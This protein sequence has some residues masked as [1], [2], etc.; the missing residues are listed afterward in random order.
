MS[1]LA[2]PYLPGHARTPEVPL[3]HFLP[4]LP[5][6]IGAVWLEQN[7]RPGDWVLDP[8]GASP[9][10]ALEAARAGRRVLVA[11]N[12]PVLAFMLEMLAAAPPLEAYQSVLVEVATSR[13]GAE[14][15]ERQILG[16]YQSRCA[17]CGVA[18]QPA[19][20]IWRKD[21]DQPFARQYCCP[22][23]GDEGERPVDPDDLTTL[24]QL[25]SAPLARARAVDR[26]VLEDGNLQRSVEE[27]LQIYRP[28]PLYVLF[29]LLNKMDALNLPPDRLRCLQAL[30]LSLCDQAT[31]LWPQAGGRYRPRQLNT[32]AVSLE[33]NLWLAL[34]QAVQQWSKAGTPTPLVRYPD[35]PPES[36]GI[37]LY[38]GR[39]RSLLP[40]PSEFPVRAVLAPL[41]RTN[42]AFWTLSALWSGWLFGR[43]AVA[44][45]KG[46]LERQR[47]D[48]IWNLQAMH[49]VLSALPPTVP[50]FGIATECSPGSLHSLLAAGQAAG[51][52]LAGLALSENDRSAQILW[53]GTAGSLP[54]Y[55]G[56]TAGLCVQAIESALA[57]RNEPAGQLT[58][59]SACLASLAASEALPRDLTQYTAETPVRL[60]QCVDSVLA[61]DRLVRYAKAA[62]RDPLWE[63]AEPAAEPLPLSDR[64]EMETVRF[65]HRNPGAALHEIQ[66]AINRS[67]PGLLT[68]P[69]ELILA[70]L[71]AYAEQ[72]ED[73][74]WT[75][76]PAENPES[77]R[78][79]LQAAAEALLEL[80]ERL[81]YTAPAGEQ[82]VIWNGDGLVLYSFA[83]LASAVVSPRLQAKPSAE[84][85]QVL[86][87]PEC[88]LPLVSFKRR[89][90]PRLSR[91]LQF[92]RLLTFERLQQLHARPDL[93]AG[94]WARLLDS[95]PAPGSQM[96]QMSMF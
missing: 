82:P 96:T 43:E 12:N 59:F 35:Q 26:V 45:L 63:L 40:L 21:E 13:R 80:A 11:C 60:Q 33:K 66:Y 29:T 91:Q 53:Q 42:P 88:R 3:A 5:A 2:Q 14:R 36:G 86:V 57:E 50:V 19:A 62:G 51:L 25:G 32:P 28:R 94:E 89:S 10:L 84:T 20:F 47:Y 74:G 38:P 76:T 54:A 79:D 46:A 92:W 41:A 73:G 6:G 48:W 17:A 81:G 69:R 49:Y 70:V 1:V 83:V 77:R 18:V 55:E 23:C 93:S 78:R 39:A 64:V 7:T 22:A 65:L 58:L 34:E 71:D 31:S 75:L 95:S 44:P 24:L 15:L 68:P 8:F 27:S 61:G 52:K 16:L 90:N 85:L 9:A 4:P 72:R 30:L 56:D 37:C 87:L 67:F